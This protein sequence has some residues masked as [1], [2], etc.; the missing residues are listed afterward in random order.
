[1]Y[2][3]LPHSWRWLLLLIASC[4]FYMCFI[5]IY[6]LIL[7][8]LILVDF[9]MGIM[10]SRA[11]GRRRILYLVISIAAT[12]MVLFSFKYYA[13]FAHTSS[14]L[15]ELVGV[16][17]RWP[18][19]QF[20]LPIGLSFHTFQSLS[21]V[22][23]VYRGKQE[24]ERNL[25]VYSLYVMFFP[26]LVA[27]PIERPQNLLHQF[28]EVHRF[29]ANNLLSGLSIMAWGFFQKM[30]IADRAAVY[31][32]RV[33]GNS[34]HAS[35]LQLLV[36]TILFAVQIYADF[37]GYSSIAIGAARVMGFSLMTNFDHPYFSASIGEFWRRWHISLSTWF[38]DYVYIPLG[39]SR[40]GP[41]RNYF[42]LIVTFAI[43]GLWHG[44]NWT[45]V[46][47][48]IYNGLLLVLEKLVARWYFAGGP[49]TEFVRRC[50]TL[51]LVLIGWVF[52]R[53]QNISQ[54]FSIIHRMIT[55]LSFGFASIEDAVLVAADGSNALPVLCATILLVGSMFL[56][57]AAQERN[58]T[59][60]QACLAK[61]QVLSTTYLV[62]LFPL[63]MLF[64]VLR[65]SS[66]I[67]FQF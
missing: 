59:T 33:Y 58:Q 28:R 12:C 62:L 32:N 37:A 10:I 24:P 42:N 20:V 54:A 27:G 46:I 1:M 44:A 29:E 18:L 55:D 38:K 31:V 50:I 40:R 11:L 64:G 25:G 66:F 21:Y 56:I 65:S 49:I 45:F 57:E 9:S 19:F 2:Y 5:P 52:F 13:F 26:Q 15:G 63:I 34:G 8:I 14:A 39:G 3:G 16:R 6:I 23:E 47:W 51:L 48:G 30:V 22:I 7:F 43:S 35:G 36:A 67:Y 17:V 53:S 41:M 61:S 4:Y 60:L